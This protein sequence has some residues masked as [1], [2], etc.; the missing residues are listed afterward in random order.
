MRV[1]ENIEF[2]REITTDAM[3]HHLAEVEGC[4][5]GRPDIAEFLDIVL[6]I[7]SDYHELSYNV[8]HAMRML[9][10]EISGIDL[11]YSPYSNSFILEDLNSFIGNYFFDDS[12]FLLEK[13]ERGEW[14]SVSNPDHGCQNVELL[15]KCA[16]ENGKL[17]LDTQLKFEKKMEERRN[18]R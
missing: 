16:K 13:N 1:H 5:I 2:L 3:N 4:C 7:S 15:I 10:W 18:L 9:V 14:K 8:T 11:Q 17:A 12:Y 6:N